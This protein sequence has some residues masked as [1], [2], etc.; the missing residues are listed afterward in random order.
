MHGASRDELAREAARLMELG[1]AGS[2]DEALR[3]A[4]DRLPER[5]RA[6]VRLPSHGLVREHARGFAMQSQGAEAYA[7]SVRSVLR[8]AEEIMTVLE[9]FDPVLAGRAA[10]GQVDAGAALHIRAYTTMPIGD[11]ARMLVD[12]G[13]DE[14]EF[15]TVNTRWGRLNRLSFDEDGIDVTITRC[16]PNMRREAGENLVEPGRVEIAT[17]ADLRARLA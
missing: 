3:L 10:K 9:E 4:V 13:Y 2:I 11:I 17:L 5:E 1:R 8:V 12:Q 16:A 15:D 14:P 7:E 6:H